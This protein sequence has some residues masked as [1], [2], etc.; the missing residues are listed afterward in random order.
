[1]HHTFRLDHISLLVGDLERSTVFYTQIM[2]FEPVER[3]GSP[4]VRWFTIGGPDTLHLTEGD[5]RTTSLT[6]NT[7]VALRTPDLDAF[8]A[9]LVEKGVTFC[10]WSGNIGKIG[11]HRAG[12]RQVYVQD[13]DGYWVEVNDHGRD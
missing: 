3:E 12:F 2:G 1:M 7:H 4:N 9:T 10:D 6:K 11:T 5:T 8:V 13:P